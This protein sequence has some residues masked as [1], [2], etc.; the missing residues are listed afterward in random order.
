MAK[1]LK[2]KDKADMFIMLEECTL[3]DVAKAF[4]FEERYSSPASM[5]VMMNKIYKE[6]RQDPTKF[7]IDQEV[8]DRVTK[9]VESRALTVKDP[10]AHAVVDEA[11]PA[12]KDIK[13]LAIENRNKSAKLISRF[14]DNL[15]TDESK[16]MGMNLSTLATTFG[17]LFDKAQ[18]VSGEAT[19][20]IAVM[21]KIDTNMTAQDMLNMVLKT[22][23]VNIEEKNSDNKKRN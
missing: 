2:T 16:L 12:V 6:V 21:A 20:N 14:L 10:D 9:A 13:S 1:P 11:L 5:K 3:L 19:E 8:A 22:R 17:I 4:K 18:I 15:G 7:G 23:E